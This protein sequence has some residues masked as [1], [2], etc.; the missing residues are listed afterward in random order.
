MR[1]IVE[2]LFSENLG[3]SLK[4]SSEEGQ[5]QVVK[6]FKEGLLDQNKKVENILKDSSEDETAKES[7]KESAAWIFR[8]VCSM[9]CRSFI[10]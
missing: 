9:V 4:G 8:L 6:L 2:E 5:G 10:K 1:D 3:E 7:Q